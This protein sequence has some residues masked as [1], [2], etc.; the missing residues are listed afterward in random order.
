MR[1]VNCASS[2]PREFPPSC[3]E[4][5]AHVERIAVLDRGFGGDWRRLALKRAK[6]RPKP[7]GNAVAIRY[8]RLKLAAGAG[9]LKPTGWRRCQFDVTEAALPNDWCYRLVGPRCCSGRPHSGQRPEMFPVR[10]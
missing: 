5:V 1:I 7:A 4:I 9:R 3:S 2:F 8:D 6:V 10:L